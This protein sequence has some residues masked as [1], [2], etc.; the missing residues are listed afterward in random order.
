ML[1]VN[2]S[3]YK[4]FLKAGGFEV[5]EDYLA[6][7]Y[8][9]GNLMYSFG[10]RVLLSS[11]VVSVFRTN[12]G[13][14]DVIARLVRW[15]RT[16]RVCAPIGYFFSIICCCM[17]WPLLLFIIVGPTPLGWGILVFGGCI[18]FLASGLIVFS[19]GSK[20]RL[21]QVALA[22]LWD[23]VSFLLWLSGFLGNRVNWGGVKYKL[24]SDGRIVE[25]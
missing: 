10:R 14:G 25:V 15:N 16:V 24:F 11:Y 9:I 20:N 21:L 2:K 1:L 3:R 6:D 7:D 22:P 18:K 12:Q 5:I 19:I 17:L 13:A 4:D 8:K 23:F